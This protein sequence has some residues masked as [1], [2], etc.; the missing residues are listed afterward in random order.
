[1][2]PILF[3]IPLP[4]TDHTITL[5]GYGAM[6][7]LGF[8]AAI[9]VAARRAKRLNQPPE[10]VY[11]IALLSFF[12]GVLG[13]RAFHVIQYWNPSTSGWEF[14]RIWEGG[15]TYYGGLGLAT[16][17]VV[18][19]LWLTRLPVLYWLDITAPSLALGLAFGRMGCTLR[20]C[21][22]GD[23][24]TVPWA[25]AWPVGTLPWQHFA[26][27]HLAA[28]G[29]MPM[30]APGGQLGA[31]MGSMAAVW[32]MP[33]IHPSQLYSLV[34]ALLVFLVLQ[35]GFMRKR[36]HGQVFLAFV[37]LYAVSRFLLEFIRAD[38]AE[39]YLMGLPTLLGWLGL[40]EAAAALPHLTISQNLA[41]AAAVAAAIALAALRRS[42]RRA[43]RA[44]YQP[45]WPTGV[46]TDRQPSSKH[47]KGK[48]R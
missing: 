19:Y 18:S 36:R 30:L 6:L 12:G 35:L 22:W 34:N 20:G 17:A 15:L 40:R 37:L 43:W 2:R 32:H 8:L 14:F 33:P 45:T 21:C 38:E 10:I 31:A 13:A 42:E 3:R 5:Y 25:F 47:R 7:C 4:G 28:Q 24:A 9:L 39:A 48:R 29:L 27:Q 26:D 1:V 44:D 11:N 23:V 16:A 41:M 46:R